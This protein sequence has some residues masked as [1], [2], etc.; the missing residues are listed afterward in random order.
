MSGLNPLKKELLQS[1]FDT[2]GK[3][4]YTE[5][6]KSP[7]E[8]ASLVV[9]LRTHEKTCECW[10]DYCEMFEL[11]SKKMKSFMCRW[12]RSCGK[13]GGLVMVG[14]RAG[15]TV[16][17]EVLQQVTSNWPLH[18]PLGVKQQRSGKPSPAFFTFLTPDNWRIALEPK[19]P[20]LKCLRIFDLSAS[21]SV[22]NQSTIELYL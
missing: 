4:S 3:K 14:G 6:P 8:S 5:I 15:R 18:P 17:S 12:C 20:F 1:V 21:K 11:E 9:A 13:R 2:H 16:V 19:R 10:R 7:G 22:L